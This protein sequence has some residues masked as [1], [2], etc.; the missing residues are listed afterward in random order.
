MT[1]GKYVVFG[2]DEEL[3][4]LPIGVVERILPEEKATPLPKTPEMILRVFDLRGETVPVV[5]LRLRFERARSQELG[6]FVVT[7]SGDSRFAL[8][9]DGVQG[10]VTLVESE[11]DENPEFFCD[12]HDPVVAGV[13]R[14]LEQLIVILDVDRLVPRPSSNLAA[15]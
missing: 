9:V 14:H 15:A 3:F 7:H 12:E 1:D 5:D 2:L 8:R 4:G 10:I 13:A 11:I 6:R